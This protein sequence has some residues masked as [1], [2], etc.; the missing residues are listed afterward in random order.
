MTVD[1][2][3]E[4]KKQDDKKIVGKVGKIFGKIGLIAQKETLTKLEETKALITEKLLEK[5]TEWRM[6]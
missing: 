5:M 2:L 6:I 3:I 1:S 4:K